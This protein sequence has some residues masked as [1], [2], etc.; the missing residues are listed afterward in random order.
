MSPSQRT[1]F[2]LSHMVAGIALAV[3]PVTAANTGPDAAGQEPLRSIGEILALPV[4]QFARQR[5]V[6]VRGVV[7]L[8]QPPVIQDGEHAIY[9]DH[10]QLPVAAG[11]TSDDILRSPPL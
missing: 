9:L 7:T 1:L 4:E 8:G 6:V 10:T 3:A 5:P 11:Q 2:L